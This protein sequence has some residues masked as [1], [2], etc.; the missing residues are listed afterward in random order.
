MDGTAG[1]LNL[2][3]SYFCQCDGGRA[4]GSVSAGQGRGCDWG[5]REATGDLRH[6]DADLPGLQG[7]APNPPAVAALYSL[8]SP[9]A[10]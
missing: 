3:V 4:P 2:S 5:H 9:V 8:L 10:S 1:L 7:P 6:Q